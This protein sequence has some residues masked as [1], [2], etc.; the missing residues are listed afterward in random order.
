MTSKLEFIRRE[1]LKL[2]LNKIN[3]RR[4]SKSIKSAVRKFAHRGININ[5]ISVI[6]G[7]H[8]T[9]LY[10]LNHPQTKKI[11]L[12]SR[13]KEVPIKLELHLKSGTQFVGLSFSEIAELF[14]I[15]LTK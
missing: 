12:K 9:T 5:E 7:I 10:Y 11:K 14:K 3:H 4:Y 15:E 2:P 6:T 8:P 1:I 13:F